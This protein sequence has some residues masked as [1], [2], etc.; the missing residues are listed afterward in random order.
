M[1]PFPA[2][3]KSVRIFFV[4]QASFN[5][6]GAHGEIPLAV[7]LHNQAESVEKLGPQIALLRVHGAH[8]HKPCWMGITDTL[9]LHCVDAHGGAVKEHIDDMVV[10]KIDLIHIEDVA[11]GLGQQSRLKDLFAFFDGLLHVQRADHP[12]FRG[13]DRQFNHPPGVGHGFE[14]S[15]FLL[16]VAA[17]ISA[18]RPAVEGA[19]LHHLHL[20]HKIRQP[21]NRSG[22]CRSL[23]SADQNAAQRGID[24]V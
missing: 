4:I 8:Q 7:D 13:A 23:F 2:F 17:Q 14:V 16:A 22:F 21:A 20:L 18:V 5:Q 3:V 9:T 24:E 12:V 19:A 1:L 15:Q 11:V 10:Q 6:L